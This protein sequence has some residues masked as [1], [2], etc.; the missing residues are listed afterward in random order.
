MEH[1]PGVQNDKCDRLSRRSQG[2]ELSVEDELVH[3]GLAGVHVLHL[4][5][6][7]AVQELLRCCDP[8]VPV[9][10]DEMF[11]NFWGGIRETVTSALR[12]LP[13]DAPP[14]GV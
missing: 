8:N 7:T 3:M 6:D 9:S 12:S 13:C 11:M 10:T 2:T 14:S 1:I 5:N 4:E